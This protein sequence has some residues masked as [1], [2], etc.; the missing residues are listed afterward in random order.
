M[1]RQIL[2]V[3]YSENYIPDLEKSRQM[4]SRIKKLVMDILYY[5][6]TRKIEWNLFSVRQ[7]TKDIM[8]IVTAN[9]EKYQVAIEEKL[10][11]L[12]Q[13]DHFE[14]DEKSL[15]TALVNIFENSIEA[16]IDNP[17]EKKPGIL[18]HTR[19]D[20]EKVLFTI[21]D[22]GLG[23]DKET[24][25]NLFTIFFLPRAIKERVWGFISPTRS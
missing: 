18:F 1:K 8:G 17:A 7:F 25:K 14:V 2:L 3:N 4:T 12:T 15:Q 24:L 10:D 13:D 21:Q 23:M 5:T 20:A 19:L 22:N 9:A 6:K 16:C 11:I